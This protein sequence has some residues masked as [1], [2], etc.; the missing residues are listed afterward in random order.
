MH[1]CEKILGLFFIIFKSFNHNEEKQ[2]YKN[3]YAKKSSVEGPFGILKEQFNIEKEV[4]IGMIR[5]EERLNLDAVAYNLIRLYNI[6]Q[7][8][9]NT[10][11]DL[12]NFCERE[13]VIH[14]L[15]LDVT[16]F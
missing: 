1:F 5:T 9:E 13:S 11:E 8:I 4:V 14:Q 15:K 2:E 3:E 16:I 10:K 7:E 6:T 12:E